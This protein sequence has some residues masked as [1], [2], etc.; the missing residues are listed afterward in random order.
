MTEETS[1]R[2]HVNDTTYDV[3][4]EPRRVLADVLR[5]DCGL[6][7]TKLGCEQGVCGSCTVLVDGTGVRSC[8]MLAVQCAGRDIRT[9]EG[10]VADGRLHAFQEAMS[11]EH[12]L[13][14]GF[15]T[16]GFVMLVVGALDEDPSIA[17]DPER[18]DS[19]LSSNLCRCTGYDGIRRAVL[20]VYGKDVR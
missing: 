6:T 19:L 10:L 11:A 1:L 16:A 7:G 14:C 9:I 12:G 18:L 20:R 2:L 4:V 17:E 3:S 13:Q 15:C 8:L 5:E